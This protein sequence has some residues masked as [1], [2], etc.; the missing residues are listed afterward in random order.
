MGDGCIALV[1]REQRSVGRGIV[2]EVIAEGWIAPQI[3]VDTHTAVVLHP[4]Q[5]HVMGGNLV[6]QQ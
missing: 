1:G 4:H 5:I 2:E 3:S 6:L